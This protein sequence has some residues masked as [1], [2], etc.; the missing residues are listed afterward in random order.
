[1]L[2]LETARA[3]EES[4]RAENQHQEAENARLQEQVS[5]AN[6]VAEQTSAKL[7]EMEVL[8]KGVLLKTQQEQEK[9]AEESSELHQ[10]IEYLRSEREGAE[11]DAAEC[12]KWASD[13][14]AEMRAVQERKELE[15]LHTVAEENV[16]WEAR[17]HRLIALLEQL[18]AQLGV[19]A[20]PRHLPRP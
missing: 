14:N 3:E 8:Y 7:S 18:Q 20:H 13:L 4:T 16:R 6:G 12:E 2:K 9:V 5:D 11:R 17:E 15:L 1:M 10:A 19:N